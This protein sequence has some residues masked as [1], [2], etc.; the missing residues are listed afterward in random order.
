ML[1][2]L[3][4]LLHTSFTPSWAIN[5]Q[6]NKHYICSCH[7][8]T[9]NGKHPSD[10]NTIDAWIDHHC[11]NSTMYKHESCVKKNHYFDSYHVSY[12]SKQRTKLLDA[13]ID[14][15]L[16]G[17]KSIISVWNV[18]LTPIMLI[19]SRYTQWIKC[20]IHTARKLTHELKNQWCCQM[21]MLLQKPSIYNS[22]DIDKDDVDPSGA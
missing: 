15:P 6:H 21:N 19:P 18:L 1:E 12:P 11:C 7:D 13:V 5:T 20:F 8:K 14:A 2:R 17:Y 4:L 16:P 3:I 10:S 9:Q 22:N